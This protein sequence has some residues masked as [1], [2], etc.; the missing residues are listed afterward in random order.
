MSNADDRNSSD[1]AAPSLTY[2]GEFVGGPYDGMV[3]Q[4][5]GVSPP[6]SVSVDQG[7]LCFNSTTRKFVSLEYAKGR[8]CVVL[9]A[10]AIDG[11]LCELEDFMQ[12]NDAWNEML[13]TAEK[14]PDG[15]VAVKCKYEWDGPKVEQG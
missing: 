1:F 4:V 5:H 15:H 8:Y 10:V 3:L 2:A 12:D 7:V 14:T 13:L 11:N 6:C 9:T